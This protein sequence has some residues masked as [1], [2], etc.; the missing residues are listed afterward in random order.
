M[1]HEVFI[2]YCHIDN[3]IANGL[4]Y[5]LEDIGLKCWIAPRDIS[6]G[7]VWAKAI[8]EAIPKCKVMLLV[9]SGSSNA[10]DQVLREVELAIQNKL[11]VI[12]IRIDDII[13]TGGMAYYLATTQWLNIKEKEIDNKIS[14]I[15]NKIKDVISVIK[16]ERSNEE[17]KDFRVSEQSP[18]QITAK[19]NRH[20]K[21]LLYILVPIAITLAVVFLLV[22]NWSSWFSKETI[23]VNTENAEQNKDTSIP[24]ATFDPKTVISIEDEIL[25]EAIITTLKNTGETIGNEVTVADMLKL[26]YIKIA[27]TEEYDN[28]ISNTAGNSE[29]QS[30]LKNNF[31]VTDGELESLNGLEYATNLT[32][33]IVAG[34]GIRDLKPLENLNNLELLYLINNE[35][36]E[37]NS[38]AKLTKIQKMDLSNNLIIDI[39]PLETLTALKELALSE[40]LIENIEP[41]N[42]LTNLESL[43]LSGNNI[44]D[45]SF[46]KDLRYLSGIVLKE[47]KIKDISVLSYMRKARWLVL[48]DNNIN[49]IE[50]LSNL[51]ELE[52]L[53][54]QGN[55]IDDLSP[56]YD[57]TILKVL[58]INE[59]TSNNNTDE[60]TKLQENGVGVE[61]IINSNNQTAA[62]TIED[63]D[64][65]QNMIIDFQDPVLKDVVFV[66]LEKIGVDISDEVTVGEMAQL[67]RLAVYSTNLDSETRNTYIEHFCSISETNTNYV[68]PNEGNL[69]DIEQLKYAVNLE[70]LMLA[71]LDISNIDSLE[72]L[73]NLQI[74]YLPENNITS[75]SPVANM[76]SLNYLNI[77]NNNV[78]DLSTLLNHP[79]LSKLDISS[80]PIQ[81]TGIFVEDQGV[82]LKH[83]ILSQD[84]YVL[85]PNVIL[86]LEG[87]GCEIEVR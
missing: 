16:E 34:K 62:S 7:D 67:T 15:S 28:M 14:I 26:E 87:V 58:R 13:P 61:V 29:L 12:P 75:I 47:N 38:L 20:P 33:L 86:E 11:V 83:L 27:S 56:L 59:Y 22:F 41:I 2:S 19:R 80:N 73:T 51:G 31:I 44:S 6:A 42:K 64:M 3:Q 4:C 71:G 9:L 60:I 45:I 78:E 74:L 18:A 43:I 79:S 63:S 69:V 40:N 8:S 48:E 72:S 25:K 68:L 30:Y 17:N 1:T 54:I 65:D 84:T 76:N 23:P 39:T 50:A 53:F 35:I 5:K 77:S 46:I 37:I 82:S 10:S 36:S 55:D 81:D 21:K 70:Y 66:A 85:N 49:N 52:F 32:G 24:I 57:C